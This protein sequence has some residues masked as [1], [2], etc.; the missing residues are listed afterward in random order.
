MVMN[1]N[2]RI[3]LVREKLNLTREQFGKKLGLA[4]ETIYDIEMKGNTVLERNVIAICAVYKVNR[5]WLETG[6]G[7]MFSPE[8]QLGEIEKLFELLKPEFQE[9]VVAQAKEVL[10]TQGKLEK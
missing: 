5:K 4:K 2:D 8:R 10:K 1:T 3:K 6:E 9:L 7:D